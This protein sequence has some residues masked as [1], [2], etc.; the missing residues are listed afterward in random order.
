MTQ[1]C[2]GIQN[3]FLTLIKMDDKM[4]PREKG[5]TR[6]AGKR[7][8][9]NR[10][11]LGGS[12]PRSNGKKTPREELATNRLRRVSCK[13]ADVADAGVMW[14]GRFPISHA[15]QIKTVF[16]FSPLIRF[17]SFFFLFFLP[18]F[19]LTFFSF[20]PPFPFSVRLRFFRCRFLLFAHLSFFKKKR[21]NLGR[22]R[23]FL[24][25]FRL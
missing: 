18:F 14:N 4:C 2:S 6:A 19:L 16:L 20:L 5:D 3:A 11:A 21:K 15:R 13:A 1:V 17:I 12:S 25:C 10:E 8:C 7:K 9:A 24:Q 22:F 23:T